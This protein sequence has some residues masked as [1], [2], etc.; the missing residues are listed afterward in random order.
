[1]FHYLCLLL[2]TKRLLDQR[3]EE[4]VGEFCSFLESDIFIEKSARVGKNVINASSSS[5]E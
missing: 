2:F 3:F 4:I 1:M 5:D